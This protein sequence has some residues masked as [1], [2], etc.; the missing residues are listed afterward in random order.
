MIYQELQT[1]YV[2]E[3]LCCKNWQKSPCQE[4]GLENRGHL[5]VLN[6]TQLVLIHYLKNKVVVVDFANAQGVVMF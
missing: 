2:L 1:H 4:T 3:L 6:D 5:K